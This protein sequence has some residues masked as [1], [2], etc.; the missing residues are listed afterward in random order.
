MSKGLA[1]EL[2]GIDAG[3][4]LRTIVNRNSDSLPGNGR[5]L[6][7]KYREVGLFKADVISVVTVT[8]RL[9]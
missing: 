9:S 6:Q 1:A 7:R 4:Q 3:Y 8:P 2:E 5:V